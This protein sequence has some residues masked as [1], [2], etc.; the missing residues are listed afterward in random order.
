MITL[1]GSLLGFATSF[2]PDIMKFFREKADR[3]HE[4]AIMDKQAEIMKLGH[5]QRLEEINVQAD[6]TE[7]Q[8]LYQSARRQLTG[9]KWVDAAMELLNSSVR[10]VITYAFFTLFAAVKGSALYLLI[11]VEGVLLHQAL[12]QIWDSETQGLFAAVL[13]FWFGSRSV[14]KYLKK[15]T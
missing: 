14:N 9:V 2:F 5:V 6:I 1:V 4:L 3:A 13:S 10:P 12:P 7:S 11:M 15:S 8:A